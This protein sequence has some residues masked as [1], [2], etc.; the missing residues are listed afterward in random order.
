MKYSTT[1]K[2]LINKPEKAGKQNGFNEKKSEIVFHV[3]L[4][5]LHYTVMF[6][7]KEEWN[8]PCRSTRKQTHYSVSMKRRVKSVFLGQR[9]QSMHRQGFNEKKSEI[10]GSRRFRMRWM[11]PPRFNEK[12]S[13]MHS[14][15]SYQIHQSIIVSMKRRVKFLLKSIG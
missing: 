13:E 14:V 9:Y 10:S 5:K 11:S 8:T 1:N 6:Q 3:K 12:K 4:V 7:W 15:V 2:S